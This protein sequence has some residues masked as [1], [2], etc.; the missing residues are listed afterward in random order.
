MFMGR[1]VIQGIWSRRR[2]GDRRSQGKRIEGQEAGK[3]MGGEPGGI[4]GSLGGSVGSE[5]YQYQG[6]RISGAEE[7]SKIDKFLM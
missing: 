2:P 6:N 7:D 5:I 4:W 1:I 3:A